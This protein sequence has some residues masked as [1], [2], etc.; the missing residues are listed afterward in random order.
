MYAWGGGGGGGAPSEKVEC[1][2]PAGD[3]GVGTVQGN[4]WP[5]GKGVKA[6]QLV[7]ARRPTLTRTDGW[8]LHVR[9]DNTCD[10]GWRGNH[11][12]V[13]SRAVDSDADYLIALDQY[14]SQGASVICVQ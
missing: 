8:I 14:L 7:H 6:T 12:H 11:F 13:R 3:Y 2:A 10:T 1:R 9:Q 4:S 5:P